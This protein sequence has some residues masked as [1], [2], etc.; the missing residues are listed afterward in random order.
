MNGAQGRGT[1]VFLPAGELSWPVQ[2]RQF[3]VRYFFIALLVLYFLSLETAA[4][5]LW[6]LDGVLSIAAVYAGVMLV[7]MIWARWRP[8]SPRRV[9]AS[10]WLDYLILGLI[11]AHDPNP[12]L[13][14]APILLT[15]LFGHGLRFGPLALESVLAGSF[16]VLP[17]IMTLRALLGGIMPETAT[18][19][20]L[21]LYAVL[22]MYGAMLIWRSE[23]LRRRLDRHSPRDETSG[24]LTRRA[25]A[26]QA[27]VL[28]NLHARSGRPLSLILFQVPLFQTG[29]DLEGAAGL[30]RRL[31][32]TCGEVLRYGL[33]S[34]DLAGRQDSDRFVVLLPDTDAA[35]GAAVGERL[36]LS[37][38]R[39]LGQVGGEAVSV[40]A[41][42]VQAPGDG[43]D[44]G[45]LLAC[46]LERMDGE[47]VGVAAATQPG[48]WPIAPRPTT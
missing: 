8:V 47:G 12:A 9:A 5:V 30:S 4:P 48:S 14:T 1:R 44:Y 15:V 32:R 18:F 6:G 37:L 34:Y 16:L 25:L 31:L 26:E 22:A 2:R 10:L 27:E 33:R 35:H 3:W 46:A 19:L 36:Q 24:V 42:R 45:S 29:P 17:G 39:R 20:T 7:L 11:V 40:R 41:V 23:R 43:S 21:F 28:F 38:Q 13:P